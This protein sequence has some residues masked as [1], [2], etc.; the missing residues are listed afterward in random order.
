VLGAVLAGATAR[1]EGEHAW[2]VPDQLK[3]QLA[4]NVGFVSPGAGYAW[5]GRRLEGDLFLGWVPASIGGEDIFA[6]TGKL[7]WLPWR[8]PIGRRWS[9]RPFTL[10]LQVTYTL[11]GEYFVTLPGR[12][13]SNYHDFPTAIRSALA[14]G[15]VV[16][17]RG[18][19]TIHE[20]GVYWEF[21]AL[22]A[23]LVTWYR[24][25]STVGPTDV[26]SLALGIRA[27]L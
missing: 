16:A 18:G 24:N 6:V 8:L 12:Y 21:V 15:G 14:L 2:Y 19:G 10:A 22:D 11:G 27:S 7:T 13:P 17:R 5:A 26:F 3:L 4:G 20:L 9:V 23:M 25:T 1:A